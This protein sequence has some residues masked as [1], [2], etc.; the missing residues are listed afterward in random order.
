MLVNKLPLHMWR[1]S[2][3]MYLGVEFIEDIAYLL[4]IAL[5]CGFT[6]CSRGSIV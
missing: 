3:G 5:Q 4:D 2:L 6:I 1:I